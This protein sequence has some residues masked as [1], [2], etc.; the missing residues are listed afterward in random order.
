MKVLI[1]SQEL[2]SKLSHLYFKDLLNQILIA[3]YERN[4]LFLIDGS[5]VTLASV[6]CELVELK[7]N[8]HQDVDIR[9]DWV[10]D[11]VKKVDE[12]PISLSIGPQ[13]AQVIFEY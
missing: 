12:Q 13:K 11:L 8:N 6:F 7:S 1:S 4:Q 5:G 2:A 10:Y 9:W 3:K